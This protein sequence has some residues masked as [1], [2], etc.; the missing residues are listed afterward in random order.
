MSATVDTP[1]LSQP[2]AIAARPSGIATYPHA[3]WQFCRR[4]P[5][6]AFGGVIV[7]I[8]LLVAVFVDGALFGSSSPWLAPD[9]YNHQHIRN[10]DQGPSLGHPM[11]TD[12]LGRDI[13]SRILYGARISAVIGFSSVAIVVLISLTLGTLSG[14]FSGWIDTIVQRV[15][16]I[17]LSVPALILLIFAISVFAGRSG[18]Y[19]RMFWIIVIVGFVLSAASV[20]VIRGAAIA[21]ANNQYVDAARVIGATNFRIVFRH[22][23]PNVVPVAIVLA[24]VNLGTAILAE[25]A[26]S[27]LGY[28]IP[29]PFPSWGAMLNI[30]GSSQF[31]AHP[32]QAIWPGLAIAF[33]VYGFNI[34]GDA[35]RDVLDPRL[36]GGR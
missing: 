14:Y 13:F 27:F 31:R 30:S 5:L 20:R 16:D 6:G 8:M 15:I 2:A 32:M 7:V 36:R 29:N 4:K 3:V 22:I 28:G 17:I 1:E 34:L 35:M 33:A 12:E 9:N 10:V 23:V 18:P 11:G 24:T 26:I 21:T 25:A 19:G